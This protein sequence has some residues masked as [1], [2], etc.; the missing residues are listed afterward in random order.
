MSDDEEQTKRTKPC[1]ECSRKSYRHF[2]IGDVYSF[3][4]CTHCR[5]GDGWDDEINI[6][7]MKKACIHFKRIFTA[8]LKKEGIKL[9]KDQNIP[10]LHTKDSFFLPVARYDNYFDLSNIRMHIKDI[11]K[12]KINPLFETYPGLIKYDP[13]E[14]FVQCVDYAFSKRKLK[15]KY[16]QD[17]RSNGGLYIRKSDEW[18]HRRYYW[19]DFDFV[20]YSGDALFH[21]KEKFYESR[22]TSFVPLQSL[23]RGYIVRKKANDR[24]RVK[25]AVAI[26]ASW[27]KKRAMLSLKKHKQC[28]VKIQALCRGYYV[29]RPYGIYRSWAL[30]NA[31]TVPPQLETIVH[32][33]VRHGAVQRKRKRVFQPT[34]YRKKKRPH[35][36]DNQK[37]LHQFWT[38]ISISS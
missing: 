38:G 32:N 21:K 3:T 17:W 34:P 20:T 30:W 27:R 1:K 36:K 19:E 23:F 16:I 7:Y 31:H 8:A 11:W 29:R 5:N 14:T 24:L 2:Y 33:L 10:K 6:T 26:Q 13:V 9:T 35:H 12:E 28:A 25:S 18:Q 4:L 15:S 37:T 22:K